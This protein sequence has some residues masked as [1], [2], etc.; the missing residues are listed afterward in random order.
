M[1]RW[2][3][4]SRLLPVLLLLPL[5]TS[6]GPA[7]GAGPEGRGDGQGVPAGIQVPPG[8][9]VT[10]FAAPPEVHYPTCLTATPDGEV[11]VGVDE[12]ANLDIKPDRGRVLRCVDAD[13]D[14]KADRITVFARMDSPRGLVHDGRTLYVLHPPDLTAYRDD[15]GDGR[16]DRSETLV[17]GIGRELSF[18]G[19][20]HT[21]N[22]IRLG[23][24]GWLYIAGGDYGFVKAMGKDGAERQLRGGGIARVRLDGSGLEVVS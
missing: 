14:G 20:D 7:R 1:N 5:T 21:T 13:G 6:P 10:L 16:A 19:A 18:H 2:A 15:D 22:G 17:R 24:D 9:E 11:Y 23:I 3:A 8:F 4:R 12:N